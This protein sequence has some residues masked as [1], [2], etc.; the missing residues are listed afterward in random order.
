MNLKLESCKEI[1]WEFVRILRQDDRVKNGFIHNTIINQQD[2]IKYMTKFANFYYIALIDNI[3]VGYV[4]VINDDIR[5]CTHPD[6]HGKG[7][8]KFMINEI[9][10]FWPNAIAKVKK[11]NEASSKLFL[12]CNFIK[13]SEDNQFIYY[14]KIKDEI[15]TI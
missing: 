12:S 5:V 3:P 13:Y 6:F 10:K 8:G 14:K 1:Y 9:H 15:N 7:I 11:T 2:Q 4:G